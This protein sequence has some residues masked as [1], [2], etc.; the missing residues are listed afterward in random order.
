MDGE[1]S[2]E[3]VDGEDGHGQGVHDLGGEGGRE[4]CV[5]VCV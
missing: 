1:E 5:C 4:G 3:V 2:G